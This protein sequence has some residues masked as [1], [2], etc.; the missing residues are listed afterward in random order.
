MYLFIAKVSDVRGMGDTGNN[1]SLAPTHQAG[2]TSELSPSWASA[3]ASGDRESP[4]G[5][6]GDAVEGRRGPGMELGRSPQ[7]VSCQL[8]ALDQPWNSTVFACRPGVCLPCTEQ[9]LDVSLTQTT[10]EQP[11]PLL[12]PWFSSH[13]QN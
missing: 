10:L 4:V 5:L 6:L 7:Q 2:V 9:A 1:S 11:V 12:Q 3:C 8:G 13:S